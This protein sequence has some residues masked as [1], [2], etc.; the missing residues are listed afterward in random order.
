ML[1]MGCAATFFFFVSEAHSDYLPLLRDVARYSIYV[2]DQ[3]TAH[4]DLGRVWF[5]MLIDVLPPNVLS[6]KANTLIDKDGLARLAD[7]GLFI[8]VSDP[9]IT[10]PQVL[11]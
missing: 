1:Y 9:Q 5:Q 3:E 4:G 7:F 8:V 2:H 10:R 6:I 11:W